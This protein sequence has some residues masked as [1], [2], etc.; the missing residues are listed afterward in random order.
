[1][2]KANYYELLGVAQNADDDEIKR[3]YRKLAM[4]HH[5]DRNPGNT[6]AEELFKEVK[7]AYE[8]LSDTQKR[9]AYDEELSRKRSR[10]FSTSPANRWSAGRTRNPAPEPKANPTYWSPPPPPP[11]PPGANLSTNIQ[12]PIDIARNGGDLKVSFKVTL[13][14]PAC[15]GVG[16]LAAATRCASCEGLRFKRSKADPSKRSKCR[17]CQGHGRKTGQPCKACKKKGAVTQKREAIISIP[18]N[19]TEGSVIR[20]RGAGAPSTEGGPNGNL[21]CTVSLKPVK[22][23]ELKGLNVHGEVK[24]DFLTA[25]LGGTASYDYLGRTLHVPVPAMC[26]AGAVLKIA[27]AGF[28]DRTSSE[29]GELRLKVAIDLPKGMRKPTSSQAAFLRDMFR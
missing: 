27:G 6:D 26:R 23:L 21:L 2:A 11:A 17:S 5:P 22:G 1:M 15:L 24:V 19:V 12:V 4:K 14:C 7:E 9:A 20:L 13:D 3:A 28:P 29:I 18:P 25:M 10:S 16:T 8:M